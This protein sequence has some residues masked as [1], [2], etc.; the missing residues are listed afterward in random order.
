VVTVRLGVLSTG[1]MAEQVARSLAD[2]TG[3]TLVAVASRSRE[4][5]ETFAER[6]G[7]AR[8]HGC[9]AGLLADPDVD[10]VYIPLPNSLHLKWTTRALRAG[11]HVL[12]E[13]P[14]SNSAREVAAAYEVA[15]G[16]GLVLAEAFM[17][18][19]NPW[20]STVSELVV[21]GRIGEL[22]LIRSAWTTTL[23]R[24]DHIALRP[25]LDG[26]VLMALGCY[27]V[28]AGRL[29]GGEPERVYGEHLAA[30]TGVDMSF[31]GSMRTA[32]GVVTQFWASFAA[33]ERHQLELCGTAGSISVSDPWYGQAP[34][35]AIASGRGELEHLTPPAADPYRI[36][37]EA[38]ARA[39]GGA[40]PP[41]PGRDETIAQARAIEA[42]LQSA[43][44]RTPTLL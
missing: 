3:V 39:V 28:S 26:G 6:H 38:F 10:A 14:F 19:H 23:T 1:N 13:K 31:A 15:D 37:L 11:K 27:C 7:A 4:R 42:L 36:E 32:E 44:T 9:Y 5:A 21:N 34:R 40:T 30:P 20:V 43:A 22:S 12:C 16:A 25:E 41:V 24:P 18:R 17:Y 35:I 2:A 29:F 8:S 33:P